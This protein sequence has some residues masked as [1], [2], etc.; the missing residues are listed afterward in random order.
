MS[1]FLLS[2]DT[3]TLCPKHSNLPS[4]SKGD[5]S[6]NLCGHKFNLPVIPSNMEDII[7]VD[8]ARWLSENGFFYVYH[9]FGQE[10]ETH[11]QLTTVS[12]VQRAVREN[13]KLISIS[14]GVNEKDIKMLS[15]DLFGYAYD[16]NFIT[17]DVAHADHENVKPVIKLIKEKYPETTLIVGNVA[18]K[19]GA[20][21][22]ALLGVD[23]I[24]VGI[25]GGSI[26]TTRYMT[27]FHVPTLQSIFD[28]NDIF[29]HENIH[30]PLIA[31]GGAKHYGDVAKA[32]TFGAMM[33][34]SGGWFASCIDSPAKIINGKKVYRGSTSFELKGHKKN[35]EGRQLEL[36]EG[37]TYEQRLTEIK[38]SIQ[39]SISYAGGTDI[40]AFKSVEWGRILPFH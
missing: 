34:M 23:C 20:M 18:T 27:G 17:I 22:L 24:K 9:R 25:G 7:S 21:Y 40:S 29:Q 3:V 32:L 31:D 28:I 33:I 37:T 5:T 2:Y 10:N 15:E 39:S 13:W 38:D 35:V 4:R 26:C 30:I 36:V 12:F 14:V 11:P 1:D 8:N 6:V 16:I 19:D